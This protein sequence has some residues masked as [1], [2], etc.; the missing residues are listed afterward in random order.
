MRVHLRR[1][2]TA[3]ACEL[4]GA[5]VDCTLLR[6]RAAGDDAGE[7]KGLYGALGGRGSRPP[8]LAGPVVEVELPAARAARRVEVVVR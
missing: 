1:G 7:A 4:D 5:A 3:A 6:A 8:A 2:Q